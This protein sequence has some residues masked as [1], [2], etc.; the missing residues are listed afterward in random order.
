VP[1]RSGDAVLA[2]NVNHL[3]YDYQL[4][5][6]GEKIEEKR[7][8]PRGERKE[9]THPGC[10]ARGPTISLNMPK[11]GIQMAKIEASVEIKRPVDKVFAYTTDAKSWPTWQST[12]PEAEQTSQGSVRVGTTFKGTIRMMGLSM[13]WTAKV[14]EYEPN[15]H[16]GKNITS[17]GLIV[18]QHNTYI[19]IEEGLKFTIVYDMKVR[20]LFKLFSP[21]LKSSMRKEL[22]KSLSNLKGILEAQS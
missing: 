9:G 8:L 11:G 1:R 12:I 2:G 14:T 10:V 4:V 15:G 16:F 13:K 17:A 3:L 19:P 5:K 18:E 21:M 22:K 7:I 20:G 6:T